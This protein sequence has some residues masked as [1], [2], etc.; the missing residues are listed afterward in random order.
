M[1]YESSKF[2]KELYLNWILARNK[3]DGQADTN[4]RIYDSKY[5]SK[6]VSFKVGDKVRVKMPQTKVGLKKKLRNDLWSD[7][8]K[9]NKI[10][11]K[12]EIKNKIRRKS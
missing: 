9:R 8:V 5:K 2:I 1:G 7:P 6:Q 10:K 12:I 3:I 11:Q 4:K